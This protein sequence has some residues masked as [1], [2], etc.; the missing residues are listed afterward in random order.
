MRAN[1]HRS[2]AGKWEAS[3]RDPAASTLIMVTPEY[4]KR[5]PQQSWKICR[6]SLRAI[7]GR[8][9]DV[10]LHASPSPVPAAPG[11]CC[12]ATSTAAIRS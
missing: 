8:A 12:G 6:S 10:T 4:E 7:F 11:A 2:P 9:K 3:K 5:I 1:V